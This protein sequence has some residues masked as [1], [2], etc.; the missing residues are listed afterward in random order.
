MNDATD[1]TCDTSSL[2][3]FQFWQHIYFNSDDSNFPR[4]SKEESGRFL[5]MSKNVG[6]DV[7]FYGLNLNT[8]KVNN[9]FNFRPAGKSSSPIIR[10]NPLT[11]PEV[12]KS[13]HVEN[14]DA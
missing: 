12:F 3:R 10:A 6:Y 13:R 9:R 5:D 7:T 14:D 2:L 1:S 4:T 8:N 11:L